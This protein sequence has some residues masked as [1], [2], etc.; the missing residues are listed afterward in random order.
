VI[1]LLEI[2]RQAEDTQNKKKTAKNCH[3]NRRLAK[4]I[5]PMLYTRSLFDGVWAKKNLYVP[6]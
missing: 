5:Q 2:K 3:Q 6:L 4:K 1:Y